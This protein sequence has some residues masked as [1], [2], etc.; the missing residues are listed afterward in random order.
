MNRA[1]RMLAAALPF[2]ASPVF[3]VIL[4]A[5]IAASFAFGSHYVRELFLPFITH[6]LDSGLA[7]PWDHFS[8]QGRPEAFPYSA[9]MLALL[10][11]PQALAGLVMPGLTRESEAF[12]LFLIRLPLLAADLAMLAVLAR[13]FETKRRTV[14]WLYWA[15]PIVFFIS[16][17]HG[18][19]DAIPSAFLLLGLA[20]LFRGRPAVSALMLGLGVGTKLHLLVA[21]PFMVFHLVRNPVRA[22]AAW[23]TPIAFLGIIFAVMAAMIGPFLSSPGYRAMVLGTRETARIFEIVLPLSGPMVIYLAPAVLLVI[24]LRFASTPK[25]N[26]DLLV[27]FL[28]LAFGA[29]VLFLPPMPGWYFWSLPLIAYFYIRQEAI[30]SFSYWLLNG[31]YVLFYA[32]FWTDPSGST[33]PLASGSLP[34][35][36]AAVDGESLVFTLLQASMAMV[37]FWIY[38]VGIRSNREY[39]LAARP[40]TIGIGGDSGSGKHTLADALR[41]LVGSEHLVQNEGD[42]YHRYERGHEA[43]KSLTHLDPR[44]NDLVRPV[45]HLETLQQG[46]LVRKP[47]YDHKSGRFTAPRELVPRRFVVVVG[48]HPFFIRKARTLMDL[49][50]FVDPDEN[51]RRHWK[52]RRDKDERGHAPAEIQ[53]QIEARLADAARYVR[54]QRRFAD[55]VFSCR[56]STPI[57]PDGDAVGPESLHSRHEIRNDLDIRRL[58]SALSGL[59]DIELAWDFDLDMERQ[60]LEIRGDPTDAAI[61]QIAYRVFPNLEELLGN[62][63]VKWHGGTLGVG[64]LIFLAFLDDLARADPVTPP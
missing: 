32:V 9:P 37:V 29:L 28:A 16:Y 63:L 34:G 5:K 52:A 50:V 41:D 12:R 19:V 11:A 22:P 49:K 14:L 27:T 35:L 62:H 42:D 17:V 13:W 39:G 24:L 1:H 58:A 18:Q 45:V 55:W 15:S 20:A 30:S 61:K 23:R 8:S 3:W 38:R 6:F 54:P 46:R 57:T 25:S 47:T 60:I 10:S 64:Q 7:N 53:A 4:A 33:L 2:R 21:V 43:W 51:L 59:T 26:R 40:V 31:M 36:P 56:P 44:A 48:L